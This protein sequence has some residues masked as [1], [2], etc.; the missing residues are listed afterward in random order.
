MPR[1]WPVGVFS[2]RFISFVWLAGWL[3]FV[4]LGK[5]LWLCGATINFMDNHF[6][7]RRVTY[8]HVYYF[9]ILIHQKKPRDRD[10]KEKYKHVLQL[11]ALGKI[12]FFYYYFEVNFFLFINSFQIGLLC[13]STAAL[14]FFRKMVFI[15]FFILFSLNCFLLIVWSCYFICNFFFVFSDHFGSIGRKDNEPAVSI[16]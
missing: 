13:D 12:L 9:P 1:R 10:G 11:L 2:V 4:V 16:M 8:I 5:R 6:K 3:C 14:F 15:V 7:K